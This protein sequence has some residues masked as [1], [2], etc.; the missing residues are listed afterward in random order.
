MEHA[1]DIV[2]GRYAEFTR[3]HGALRT[4][5]I[6]EQAK[7]I[8]MERHGISPDEAFAELRGRARNTHQSVFEVAQ[9]VTVSYPLF[10]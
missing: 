4:G 3:L 9:A 10:K 5:A 2:L 6:I 8:L 7:G 1:I